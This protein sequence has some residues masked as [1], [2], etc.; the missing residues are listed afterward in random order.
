MYLQDATTGLATGGTANYSVDVTGSDRLTFILTWSDVAAAVNASPATVNTLRLEVQAPNGDVWTQKLPAGY[1]VNNAN[2]TQSTA[3][4]NYDN[5]NTLQRIQFDTPAAGTYQIRVRGINVPSGPQKFALA[6]TGGFA[7]GGGTTWTVTPSVGSGTGTISPSTPQTV[8]GGATTSFALAAGTGFAID[9]VGGTC[10]GT[11][12]GSTY[13][14]NAVTANCTVIANFKVSGGGNPNLV[15]ASPNH[16][17]VSTFDGSSINWITGVIDDVGNQIHWNPYDSGP[18]TGLSFFWPTAGN[19]G[20]VGSATAYSVLAPGA[21]I[22]PSSTFIKLTSQAATAAWRAGADGYMG[23]NLNCP[24]GT[25]YGYAHLTTT[26][27]SGFPAVLKDYCYDKSGAPITIVGGGTGTDPVAA[28]TPAALAITAP[29]NG[30]ASKPLNIANTGGGSL[31]Y[32]ITE[33]AAPTGQVAYR[34]LDA[35]SMK[36]GGPVSAG[37]LSQDPNAGNGAAGRPFT[38]D[39]TMISQMADNTPGD[40]GVSC[41]Q[42]GVSTS[43]N[44]WWRRFYFSEHAAVGASAAI[45]GVTVS[46]GSI[47]VPGG[48]PVTINLYTIAHSTPVDTIPTSG[49]TLIGTKAGVINGALQSVTIPVTGTVSDTV[50]KDLVV[51]YHTDGSTAGQFF[52]GANATAE[53]HPTFISSTGCGIAQPTKASGIGFPDFHLTMV[54]NVDDGGTPPPVGCQNPSDIPWLSASPTSGAV[55]GG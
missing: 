26:A 44:S 29:Q 2:P 3:T 33:S 9:T 38:L 55:A 8:N 37:K 1:N 11:L 42:T 15:C 17:L 54:V 48:L 28:I 27:G 39:A 18:P 20:G 12:A 32:A 51:E 53:T 45:T 31:T 14:T 49:L 36:F 22:G 35:N 41:G 25:C 30:A 10:G 4:S 24:A 46:G 5:I 50:G 47:A 7:T 6:A 21:V 34:A 16:N 19:G 40:E 52:P 43:D 23:F 13:T